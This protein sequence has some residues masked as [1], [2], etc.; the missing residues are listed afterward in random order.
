MGGGENCFFYLQAPAM[1][2]SPM[3][4]AAVYV[5]NFASYNSSAVWCK[6][7]IIYWSLESL[8][9][10]QVFFPWSRGPASPQRV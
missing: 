10:A 2:R 4:K 5:Y 6:F 7:I 8:E 9:S 1:G 3:V